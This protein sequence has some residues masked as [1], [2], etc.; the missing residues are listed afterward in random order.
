MASNVEIEIIRQLARIPD[1]DP[2]KEFLLN[3]ARRFR[4]H[5]SK[6]DEPNQNQVA[7]A[8]EKIKNL[9]EIDIEDHPLA[10]EILRENERTIVK[11]KNLFGEEFVGN[12]LPPECRQFG[13]ILRLLHKQNIETKRQ[14]VSLQN[15]Y[16][17]K[18]VA[19]KRAQFI[20]AMQ[21]L[22]IAE[23]IQ[24]PQKGQK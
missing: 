19:G 13:A 22:A 8:K 23:I 9:V 10:S 5:V 18:G 20:G 16:S 24:A 2:D 21:D 6:Q 12:L 17:L 15:I 11:G 3:E 4:R 7:E 1:D 14:L